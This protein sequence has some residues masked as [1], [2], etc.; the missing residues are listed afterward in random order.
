MAQNVQ[1]KITAFL[2]ASVQVAVD[3]KSVRDRFKQLQEEYSNNSI[4]NGVTQAQIDG[5]NP[6][7]AVNQLTPAILS[8]FFGQQPG[9]ETN[10]VNSIQAYLNMLPS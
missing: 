5:P 6:P 8:S 1:A 7:S 9:F 3:L 10:F 4:F 2:T